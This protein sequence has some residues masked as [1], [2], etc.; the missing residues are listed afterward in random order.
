M[1]SKRKIRQNSNIEVMDISWPKGQQLL[2]TFCLMLKLL[3]VTPKSRTVLKR[4]GIKILS[5]VF[6]AAGIN[7]YGSLFSDIQSCVIIK[8][9]AQANAPTAVIPTE[10]RLSDTLF[11]YFSSLL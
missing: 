1:V 5:G 2:I 3:F 10:Y 4:T 6:L 9:L 11:H 8:I 7:Y